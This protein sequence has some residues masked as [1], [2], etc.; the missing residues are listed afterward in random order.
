[1]VWVTVLSL[2]HRHVP[3]ASSAEGTSQSGFQPATGGR[4]W[5]GVYVPQL[6]SGFAPFPQLLGKN[7]WW[8]CFTLPGHLLSRR[9]KGLDGLAA[10]EAPPGAHRGG[11][12]P[13]QG[14]DLAGKLTAAE[15]RWR[16]K[17]LPASR[18]W[19]QAGRREV[20]HCWHAPLHERGRLVGTETHHHH[21]RAP[22]GM[23]LFTLKHYYT[24]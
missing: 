12:S 21:N 6:T 22:P 7:Y 15:Q 13:S 3:K 11:T 9:S 8:C 2:C 20:G 18:S 10:W 14:I 5:A 4:C 19:G 23:Y 16:K 17:S 24:N 1:M